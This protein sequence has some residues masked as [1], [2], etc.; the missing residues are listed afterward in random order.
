M[1]AELTPARIAELARDAQ[2]AFC[3]DK[4]PSFEVAL[5]RK[6]EAALA[7]QQATQGAEPEVYFGLRFPSDRRVCLSTIFDTE[8]EAKDYCDQCSPGT[9][10]VPL[11]TAPPPAAES[12]DRFGRT[13]EVIR[14]QAALDAGDDE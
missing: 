7:T 8:K 9:V 11:Y 5:V 14:F 1:A 4:Y 12:T 2:I 3:L 10:V 13:P 6:V